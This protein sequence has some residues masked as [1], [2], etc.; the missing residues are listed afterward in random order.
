MGARR[1]RGDLPGE[2]GRSDRAQR[3]YCARKPPRRR[4]PSIELAPGRYIV[5]V[6]GI[7]SSGIQGFDTQHSLNVL[8][9][10]PVP[11]G[12]DGNAGRRSASFQLDVFRITTSPFT[13]RIVD[14]GNSRRPPKSF[15]GDDTAGSQAR[16]RDAT[17]GRSNP[18]PPGSSMPRALEVRPDPPQNLR[19]AVQRQNLSVAWDR[20]TNASAYRV[21]V[22]TP[23]LDE[24]Q[25][26][27]AETQ[28]MMPDDR[29]RSVYCIGHGSRKCACERG[30]GPRGNGI[31]ASLVATRFGSAAPD[32]RRPCRSFLDRILRD[33]PGF[34][35]L[36]RA[37]PDL[38]LV[39]LFGPAHL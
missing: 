8:A 11:P 36:H 19:T 34:C 24:I 29:L 10:S 20:V 6:R 5:S 3:T 27:T 7:S 9:N 21:S 17:N 25:I 32:L 18:K 31:K 16:S 28:L 33:L 37:Q 1:R 22:T 38:W 15:Y 23:S 35:D 2:L 12:C 26:E 39:H 13:L 30:H 14:A 4:S